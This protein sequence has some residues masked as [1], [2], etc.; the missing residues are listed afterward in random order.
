MIGA[1]IIIVFL[2]LVAL[3]ISSISDIKTFEV[4]DFV[5]YGLIISVLA[6][7]LI[8]AI[9]ES[10]LN[11]FLYGLFGFVVMFILAHIL[12]YVKFWGGGDSKLLMGLGAAFGTKPYFIDTNFNF[13]LILLLSIVIVGSVYGL[14]Y[15][16]AMALKHKVEF[17]K[18]FLKMLKTRKLNLII[19]ISLI[20]IP[21]LLAYILK[22]R[23]SVVLIF[24]VILY[25]LFHYVYIFTKSV[26]NSSMYDLIPVS[27]LTEGDWIAD[28][29]IKKKFEISYLGIEKHQI[30]LLRKAKI[31]K[32][33]VKKGIP[34]TAAIFIGVI[35]VLVTF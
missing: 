30:E 34:F 14:V 20:V 7:R 11:Y 33:L 27:K 8:G 22:R 18:E 15:S 9:L 10:D 17:K 35:I 28:K 16:I 1:D 26:E 29:N 3:L 4:P 5:S 21:Y 13:L 31:K 6:V 2:V 25:L 19:A 12:Y 24:P 23:F 32:V